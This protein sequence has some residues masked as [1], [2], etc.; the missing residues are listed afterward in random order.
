MVTSG[1]G[2]FSRSVS[3]LCMVVAKVCKTTMLLFGVVVNVSVSEKNLRCLFSIGVI[4]RLA[5]S[6]WEAQIRKL[7]CYIWEHGLDE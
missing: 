3:A 2:S 6:S 1:L 5:H 7:Y 4:D